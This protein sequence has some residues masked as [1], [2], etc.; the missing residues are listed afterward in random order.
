MVHVWA[1]EFG[2]RD[3]IV[4]STARSCLRAFSLTRRG[5]QN[6]VAVNP[7]PVS[8]DMWDANSEEVKAGIN[9]DLGVATPSEI[10]DIIVVSL[11]L[12]LLVVSSE[13]KA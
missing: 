13:P 10:S 4:S 11:G 7:G 3:G 6:C 5:C 9:A 1:N 12:R 2:K 8:T